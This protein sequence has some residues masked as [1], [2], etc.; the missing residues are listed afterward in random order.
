MKLQALTALM[1]L[2]LAGCSGRRGVQAVSAQSQPTANQSARP[3][4]EA[5]SAVVAE[6]LPSAADPAEPVAAPLAS[7]G[8]PASPESVRQ[9]APAFVIPAGTRVRVRLAQT[10]DTKY[11]RAGSGFAATLN[12]PIVEGN[13]V[14]VPKGTPFQGVVTESKKSGRFK[15]RAVLQVTLRSF[16]LH[17][18]T[19]AVATRSDSR[20]SGSHKKRNLA[21]IGGGGATGA[22]IGAIAGGGAGA[23]IGAGA[24]AAA[25][26][27]T[28]F[29]TGK[30]NVRLPVETEMVF[31]LRAPLQLRRV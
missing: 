7:P 1:I 29:I 20:I 13:R 3:P 17:G 28:E 30:K 23:L 14:L 6:P 22:G 24:G 9:V 2:A 19:Y 16:R 27:T 5:Q 18:V 4:M 21:V 11:I 10:L 31:R 26:A 25:G 15:G 12:E 8:S